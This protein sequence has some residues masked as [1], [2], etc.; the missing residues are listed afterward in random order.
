VAVTGRPATTINGIRVYK[1]VL[2]GQI[3]GTVYSVPSLGVEIMASG[4]QGPQVIGSLAPSVRDV[5]LRER[6]TGTGPGTWRSMSFAGLDFAVPP[7][8]PVSRTAYAFACD[9]PDIAFSGPSVT[10]DTDTNVARL[11]CP[12]PIPARDGTNGVQIDEGNMAA[13]NTVPAD[14][15]RLVVNG[16]QMYVDGAYPFSSLVLEVELPGRTTP[17]RVTIGLGTASTAGAVLRSIT[18]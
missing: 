18:A 16:L 14:G 11:P 4:P 5:V 1:S 15:R 9:P 8:W 6:A 12:Y 10:L 7:S 2:H 3:S 13:P 17:V